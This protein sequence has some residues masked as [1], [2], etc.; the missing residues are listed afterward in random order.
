MGRVSHLAMELLEMKQ[1]LFISVLLLVLSFQDNALA[2]EAAV[3]NQEFLKST[4]EEFK[5][6]GKEKMGMLGFGID[7]Q[8]SSYFRSGAASY[9]AVRGER[10]GFITLGVAATMN[11]PLVRGLE[12]DSGLFV[13]A[14]GGHGGYALSGGGLMVRAH[15][16]A[17]YKIGSYGTLGL[18]VSRVDF[19]NGGTIHSTQP[20]VSYAV[21]FYVLTESGW[22][23]SG[24]RYLNHDDEKRLSPAVHEFGLYARNV[25]VAPGAR[26]GSGSQQADFKLLGAEWRTYL[27]DTVFAKFESEGAAGGQSAGYMHILAGGGVRY[28]LYRRLFANVSVAIGGGGGGGVDT[29]GGLL[30]DAT[31][32]M[33]YFVAEHTYIDVSGSY[34]K[35]PSTSFEAKSIGVKLGYQFGAPG[36]RDAARNEPFPFDPH[37]LRV[38]LTSQTYLTT[39]DYWSS[40]SMDRTVDNLGAQL[41][42]FVTPR[43]FITGQG[44]AAYRGNAGAYMAGLTGVGYRMPLKNEFFAEVEGLVGAAG[45]GGVPTGGGMVA[46][47]NASLGYTLSESMAFMITL[48]EMA[49]ADG[50]F[51]TP[52][53]GV[54]LAFTGRAYSKRE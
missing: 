43:W 29:G 50:Q 1:V 23:E 7:H 8:L 41:D 13:G 28:P 31:V 37:F 48:G 17:N 53:A 38:R 32:G 47:A 44:F 16:G 18:G 22:A 2:E 19:P 33:Q 12:L 3:L 10:G 34:L 5:L 25:M 4:Y 35:A 52:V 39:S 11:Y 45:G 15:V 42:Y 49:S 21:P 46:Q 30:A 26:T 6:P 20:Y 24:T 40:H 9:A 27:S 54:S 51:R 14:G 36:S